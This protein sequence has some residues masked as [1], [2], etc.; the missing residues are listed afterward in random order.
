MTL[1]QALPQIDATAIFT[2]VNA[3]L[4]WTPVSL[5]VVLVF[6]TAAVGVIVAVF[7]RAL[8]RG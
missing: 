2:Y 1:G 5:W 3:L 6:S 8:M 7:M 4:N